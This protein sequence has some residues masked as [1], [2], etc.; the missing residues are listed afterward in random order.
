MKTN[1]LSKR[2]GKIIE[3]DRLM[4]SAEATG[5]I[6][7]D[8]KNLLENYFNLSGKVNLSVTAMKDCYLITISAPASSIK[9]F[10]IVK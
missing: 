8:L 6:E 3:S 5:L 4:I 1:L 9:T 2:L 10:G 7:Y